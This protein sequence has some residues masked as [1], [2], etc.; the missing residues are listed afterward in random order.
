MLD[1]IVNPYGIGI[2]A[3]FVLWAF[4]IIAFPIAVIVAVVKVWK[5]KDE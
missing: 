3:L 1:W 5:G 4:L 2:D